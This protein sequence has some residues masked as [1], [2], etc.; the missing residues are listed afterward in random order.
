MK[1]GKNPAQAANVYTTTHPRPR[2]P[3]RFRAATRETQTARELRQSSPADLE[4][5]ET[6]PPLAVPRTS[7][8]CIN[9]HDFTDA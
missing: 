5:L 3:T 8:H 6:L 9:Q 4:S 1:E 2:G 7:T